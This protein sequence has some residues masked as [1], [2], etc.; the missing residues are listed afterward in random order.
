MYVS[1]RC[2]TR[3]SVAQEVLILGLPLITFKLSSH[4]EEGRILGYDYWNPT[5]FPRRVCYYE[6]QALKAHT[7]QIS[8]RHLGIEGI[9]V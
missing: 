5:I 4:P 3:S 8:E 1:L 7:A 6:T 9:S 2:V